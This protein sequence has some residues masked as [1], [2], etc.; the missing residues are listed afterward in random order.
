MDVD[1][2]LPEKTLCSL[3]SVAN[4]QQPSIVNIQNRNEKIQLGHDVMMPEK[5]RFLGESA[6]FGG[7][8]SDPS[9]ILSLPHV[10]RK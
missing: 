10:Q 9:V 1:S 4:K 6:C 2:S 5:E 8:F 3:L 7:C